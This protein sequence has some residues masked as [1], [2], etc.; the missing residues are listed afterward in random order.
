MACSCRT[1]ALR[2][3]IRGFAQLHLSATVPAAAPLPQRV[4]PAPRPFSTSPCRSI[5]TSAP[6]HRAHVA[7][8]AE[9]LPNLPSA[10][11]ESRVDQPSGDEKPA[12]RQAATNSATTDMSPEAAEALA[13]QILSTASHESSYTHR[14]DSSAPK[15]TEPRD[16]N[17]EEAAGGH[18][19]WGKDPS[20]EDKK[21]RRE[22]RKMAV[23]GPPKENKAPPPRAANRKAEPWQIQ[24]EA[25]KKKF[26][27]E[28]WNPRK[29]LSPDAISGIRAL[30]AEFPATF[31][32]EWL[33][34][35]FK[36]SPEMIRRILKS[37]WRPTPEEEEDRERRWFNRGKKIWERN[38][39]LGMRVPR[40]WRNVGVKNKRR[41]K[42]RDD[43]AGL[44]SPFSAL[45]RNA[46]LHDG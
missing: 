45:R 25:L 44:T 19:R 9:S 33:A 23:L 6:C 46:Y 14:G 29:R 4:R 20:G 15:W 34:N 21:D 38:A 32:T 8:S 24:K 5:S 16:D 7:A 39:E 2:L 1:T 13:F 22:R 36:V 11:E 18:T 40:S 31:T 27:D 26:G 10:P 41:P 28:G 17:M 37:K 12:D 42:P 3:F 30:H 43:F 35:K